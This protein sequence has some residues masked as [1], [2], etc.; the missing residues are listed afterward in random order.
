MTNSQKPLFLDKTTP[1]HISTLILLSG[2]SALSMNIFLP[3]LPSMAIFFDTS[4]EIMQLAIALFLLVNAAAQVIV[5]PL[6]DRFGRRPIILWGIALFALATLG[7]IFAPTAEIFLFFRMTQATIVVGMVLSRAVIRDMVPTNEAASMIGY[8]TMGMSI[9]PM[10]A[11]ALGGYLS[12]IFGW[13]INFWL[14]FAAAIALWAMAYRDLGE[15]ATRAQTSI[16][17]QFKEYPELFGSPRF[18]GYVLAATFTSGTFFSYLGG[19]PIVADRVYGL[20]E[21]QLGLY[22]GA[23]AIGYF[24]GN[25]ISGRYSQR[26]GIDRMIL[27]GALLTA[28]GMALAFAIFSFTNSSA[29]VFF[30]FMTFVG[31]GNGMVLPNANAGML[32]VRPHLAGSAS[33]IGGA[34]MIGGGAALSAYAGTQLGDTQ[35][36]LPLLAIMMASAMASLVALGIVALRNR[37]R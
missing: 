19:A 36:P 31:L 6:S 8:V 1:P 23:P 32:S 24:F 25:F 7:C 30:A 11:P 3:S 20:S 17:A 27:L 15:T 13:Q 9:V 10:A 14:M 37:Q 33:G 34:I 29:F 12:E 2:L 21:G 5:G 16:V 28:A 22:F 35:S 18:W 4:Y 26:V